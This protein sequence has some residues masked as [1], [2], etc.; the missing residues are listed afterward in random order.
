MTFLER[1]IGEKRSSLAK[2]KAA[3][4]P[5]ELTN[6]V[7]GLRP[8]NDFKKAIRREHDG[9]VNVIAEIKRSS[10][11]KGVIVKDIDPAS[12]A[13]EYELGE[14]SAMSVLTEASFFGG[15]IKDFR[16]VREA[17]PGM[18]LL[19][20]DFII[21]E[22]QIHESLLIGADA[23]LLIVAILDRE[24]VKRFS[25]IAKE[26]GLHALV[27]VHREEELD[28]ALSGG[29][30]IIGVN[31]RDLSTFSVSAEVSARLSGKMPKEVVSV[32]ESG[33][34]DAEGLKAAAELGYHAILIGEHFMRSNDRVAELKKFT[35]MSSH[36]KIKK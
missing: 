7:S 4:T 3:L 29:A 6:L 18:P 16:A 17:V 22:Y 35:Q 9:R 14:A 32:S 25:A 27:E 11:S 15:S 33:I 30:E 36:A 34:K 2:E 26:C 12:V 5:T 21:D 20:K 13:K 31:N 8:K 28:I 10:P 19:R 23:I 24:T 1:I